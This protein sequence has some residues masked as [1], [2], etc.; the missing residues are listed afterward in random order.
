MKR[1]LA[2]VTALMLMC[3]SV[4]AETA[5]SVH[6]PENQLTLED[7]QALN[8][9]KANAYFDNDRLCFL[10]GTCTPDPVKTAGD[11][12]RVVASMTGL[13]GGDEKTHFELLRTLN[14]ASG[15]VY[16]VFQQTYAD[17]LVLGGAAKV[18]A[19]Q[20]GNML[21]LIGSVESK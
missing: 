15:N 11:A 20:A 3:A 5:V 6:A 7:I 13:L 19:D 9:G 14:D 12:E 2:L 18:I 1:L 16:F 10:E 17:L 8:E 21:G 4:S